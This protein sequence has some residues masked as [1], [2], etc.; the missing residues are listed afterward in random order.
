L[1]I[2]ESGRKRSEE[3]IEE[4]GWRGQG[5]EDWPSWVYTAP[6]KPQG[7]KICP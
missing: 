2:R 3:G 4:D 7:L 1:E 5:R 6:I